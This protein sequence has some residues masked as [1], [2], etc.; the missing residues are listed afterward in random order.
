MS[1]KLTAALKLL[2][3][4]RNDLDVISCLSK[5]SPYAKDGGAWS[6]WPGA[7]LRLHWS[8]HCCPQPILPYSLEYHPL[9]VEIRVLWQASPGV[10]ELFGAS[11]VCWELTQAHL[12]NG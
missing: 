12:L 10:G 5:Q 3:V 8:G 1:I 11:C 4:I 6:W 2:T 7:A 9:Y